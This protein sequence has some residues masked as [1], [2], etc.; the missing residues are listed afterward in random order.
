MT[1][2]RD[3]KWNPGYTTDAGNLSEQF[4]IPALSEAVRYDRGTAYFRARSLV[5]NMLGIEGLIR[6]KGKMRM[7]V[8][9]TLEADEIDAIRRGE[10][11]KKQVENNLRRIQLDPPDSDTADGLELLSWMIASGY[12]VIRIAV[13]CG[14]DGRPEAGTA[15]FHKKIGTVEDPSGD[16]NLVE[17]ER[18]RDPE[19]PV[20]QQRIDDGLHE[21]G[22]AQI[23][24]LDRGR[25]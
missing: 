11:L 8:G 5:R 20:C 3:K 25:V 9:C 14:E 19:R 16:K 10:D 2:L 24:A 15:L 18:Q 13:R 7:L 4:Y 12:L 21:L 23:P 6:K 22:G 1:M 17:G